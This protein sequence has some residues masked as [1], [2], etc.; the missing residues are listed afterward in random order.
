[1]CM[2]IDLDGMKAYFGEEVGHLTVVLLFQLPGPPGP[3]GPMVS[4]L[5]ILLT[6]RFGR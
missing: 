1:M 6:V 2:L 4:Q 3:P 5:R